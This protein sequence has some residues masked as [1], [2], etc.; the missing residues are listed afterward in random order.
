MGFSVAAGE[1]WTEVSILDD[2]VAAAGVADLFR[3]E[4]GIRLKRCLSLEA[5][6]SRSSGNVTLRL[7]R[8]RVL[9]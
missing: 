2:R 1:S 7:F 3:L 6:S 9:S 4:T 8:A 5:T